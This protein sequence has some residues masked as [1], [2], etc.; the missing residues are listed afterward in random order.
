MARVALVEELSRRCRWP[1]LLVLFIRHAAIPI[2]LR[3]KSGKFR[4]LQR[5]GAAR[6]GRI[7]RRIREVASRLD[8]LWT[9][10]TLDL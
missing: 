9:L 4:G 2:R 5:F 1:R 3:T 6:V 10:V 7:D 8:A